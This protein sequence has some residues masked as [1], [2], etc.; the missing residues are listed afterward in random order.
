M[1]SVIVLWK[2]VRE[3]VQYYVELPACLRDC[4]RTKP[5]A[6]SEDAKK[7]SMLPRVVRPPVVASASSHTEASDSEQSHFY[8]VF[9]LSLKSDSSKLWYKL[10]AVK[11]LPNLP[12]VSF[13]DSAKDLVFLRTFGVTMIRYENALNLPSLTRRKLSLLSAKFIMD[14]LIAAYHLHSEGSVCGAFEPAFI[15]FDGL[16]WRLNSTPNICTIEE[17]RTAGKP[18]LSN[19]DS[20]LFHMENLEHPSQRDDLYGAAKS[21]LLGFSGILRTMLWE[22]DEVPIFD[23]FVKRSYYPMLNDD[24]VD[25]S[26]LL[27]NSVPVFNDFIQKCSNHSVPQPVLATQLLANQ[28]VSEILSRRRSSIETH[29]ILPSIPSEKD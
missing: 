14:I 26:S 8:N 24:D 28:L 6:P 13:Y 23:E 11:R 29:P 17:A 2:F 10:L 20:D 21:A 27:M 1:D 22:C 9:N 18:K 19:E 12:E 25:A 15:S 16:F 3:A 5:S 7:F 4:F